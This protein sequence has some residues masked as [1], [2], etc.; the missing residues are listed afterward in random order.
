MAITVNVKR[1]LQFSETELLNN[2]YFKHPCQENSLAGMQVEIIP[3]Q[4]APH[5]I[6]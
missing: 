3:G 2:R 4:I 6:S 5:D 1:F